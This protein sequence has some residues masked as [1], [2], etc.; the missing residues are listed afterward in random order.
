M[1]KMKLKKL[2]TGLLVLAMAFQMIGCGGS[3][4]TTAETEKTAEE[5]AEETAEDVT[6]VWYYSGN[7]MQSDTKM[8]Q[9]AFNE[10]LH[11][12]EGMEHVNVVLNTFVYEDYA[13]GVALAQSAG[14]QMDIMQTFFLD[15]SKEVSNGSL[16]PLNDLLANHSALKNELDQWVW[17]LGSVDGN[18]YIV[19]CLQRADNSFYFTAPKEYVDNYGDADEFRAVFGNSDSTI[20]DYAALL[21]KWIVNVQAG[22]GTG[23]YLTP[24][25]FFYGQTSNG[26]RGVMEAFDVLSKSFVLKSSSTTVG[27]IYTDETFKRACEITADWYE[28][29]Y[30]FSDIA[31]VT[32]NDYIRANMMNEESFIYCI[33]NG[34]GSE[35]LQTEKFSTS[36]NFDCYAF[37]IATEKYVANV[38][39][40]GG[41]GITSSCEHPEEAMRLLEIINT[42]E[43]EELYNMLIYGIEDVHYKKIDDTHIETL[44]YSNEEGDAT[45]SFAGKKWIIGNTNYAWINQ[46]GSDEIKQAGIELN[47]SE[48]LVASKLCGFIADS[49][50]VSTEIDQVNAITSEYVNTL[51]YGVMGADWEATY[52]E[53]IEALETAGYQ[54]VI[55]EFQSQVD[56][57]LEK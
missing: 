52:N 53:F 12:F 43:G 28:K 1:K 18:V 8:V 23:K 36:Y 6:L 42:A 49:D 40:A 46:G 20:E 56:A 57:F 44:D 38:W 9:D 30:V 13:Q 17:D 45:T 2:L 15:F 48:D 3:K 4:E 29:G 31:S 7:G 24:L 50:P 16:M 34:I 22:E 55:D 25:A 10:K 21:E 5:T 39:A 19:P 54:T 33:S 14:E 41:N 11:E 35:E 26:N 47:E 51:Q 32:L 27:N 37:P